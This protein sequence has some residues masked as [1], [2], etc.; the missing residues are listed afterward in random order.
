MAS[1]ALDRAALDAF[2]KKLIDDLKKSLDASGSTASGRTK[3]SL[4][5]EISENRYKLFGR[6]YIGAL[7]FGRKPTV[8][9]GDGSLKVAIESWIRA[10]GIIP[11]A[12]ADDKHY[13]SMAFAIAKTIH[14]KGTLLFRTGRNFQGQNKPTQIIN[15]VIND[16]RI[17][18][19]GSQILLHIK[20]T[21]I[22]EIK[23]A[24]AS[25]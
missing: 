7:E 9:E 5:S 8:T 18:T 6:A 23:D 20:Q 1:F 4:V 3:E 17:E 24:Y 22:T 16:G 2:D 15:G 19:L 11:K 14:E 13:K 12:G 21:I 25:N 10:K